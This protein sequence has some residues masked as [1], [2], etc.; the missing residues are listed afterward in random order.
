M[1]QLI[2]FHK[3]NKKLRSEKMMDYLI[4]QTKQPIRLRSKP[5][6]LIVSQLIN[7]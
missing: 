1:D 7:H 2:P 4:S 3:T 6:E 5:L